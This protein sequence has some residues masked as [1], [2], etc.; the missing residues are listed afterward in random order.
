MNT[1]EQGEVADI[2][3]LDAPPP[4]LSRGSVGR[5][6]DAALTTVCSRLLHT[7]VFQIIS[8]PPASPFT[9]HKNQIGLF[10]SQKTRTKN[11]TKQK[12]M[13]GER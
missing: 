2:K 7:D 8:Q 13:P 11:K 6:G 4:P 12:Q 1:T 9:L 3:C 10:L 5:R